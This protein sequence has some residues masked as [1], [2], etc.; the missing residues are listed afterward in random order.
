MQGVKSKAGSVLRVLIIN[1][2]QDFHSNLAVAKGGSN[3]RR[4]IRDCGVG[5]LH[6][7]LIANVTKQL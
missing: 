7:R 4:A 2:V 1:S 6:F 5:M 3:L